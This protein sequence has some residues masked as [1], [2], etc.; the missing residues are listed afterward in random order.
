MSQDRL[1][2][3]RGRVSERILAEIG[4]SFAP[5]TTVGTFGGT[6]RLASHVHAG[7]GTSLN[8]CLS[9]LVHVWISVA[10]LLKMR[11]SFVRDQEVGGSNPLAPIFV[12]ITSAYQLFSAR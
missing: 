5:E 1:G 11:E 4:S 9:Y 8:L 6:L 2:F 10:M 12:S 7:Q 3:S